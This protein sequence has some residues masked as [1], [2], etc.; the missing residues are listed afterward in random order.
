MNINFFND[1][2]GWKSNFEYI[3]NIRQDK[4]SKLNNENNIKLYNDSLS[5]EQ[6]KIYMKDKYAK[7]DKES[8]NNITDN[9]I[10]IDEEKKIDIHP[11]KIIIQLVKNLKERKNN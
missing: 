10:N 4:K 5:K 7:E 6:K 9:I 3:F 11:K 1:G 8:T 2:R